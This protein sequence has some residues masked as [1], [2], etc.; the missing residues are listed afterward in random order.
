MSDATILAFDLGT[1][2]LKAA[3]ISSKA[4]VLD[5][6]V[7]P[8]EVKLLPGGGAEQHPDAWWRAMVTAAHRLWGRG[9]VKAS[10]VVGIALSSQW[11]G[12]VAVGAKGDPLRAALIWMDSRGQ[13][14]VR[15]LVSGFPMVAGYGALKAVTWLRKTG[16]VP[17]L[18]GKDPVGHIAWLR[19]HEPQTYDDAAVFLEPKDWVNARLTGR[20]AASFDSIVLHWATDNRKVDAIAYDDDLLAMSGMERRKLPELLPASS[21][22]GT[23]TSAAAEALGVS[24]SVKVVAGSA[25]MH[26]AA[27]GA[28]TVE[29][30]Q[31]HLCLGTSSWLLAHVPFKKSDLRH[32]MTSLPSAIPG[33]Y[34]W[35][36]EQETAA[37]ALEHLV[38]R[39]FEQVG[40]GAFEQALARA[41]AVAP[42]AAGLSFLPWL[43]GERS[44][45]DDHRV[46]GGF[47]GL[48][49][50]H[51]QGHLVRA[52]LEGGA[53]NTRWLKQHVEANF[54]R[55]LEA[56]T[57]VGGGARSELWCQIHADVLGRP[58]RQ[59]EDPQLAN[60]R[61][62]GLSALVALGLASWKDVPALVPIRRTFEPDR[63]RAALYAE[64]F[65]QLLLEFK[66][67]REMS[68]RFAVTEHG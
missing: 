46:R 2:G 26:M 49:L 64:R 66:H 10:E 38:E 5:R 3:I 40:P 63:E 31:A 13:E 25:D 53:L 48:S 55:P 62:A 17:S 36:N 16:G 47:V 18:S 33:R 29:D 59:V 32:N 6:E 44:P 28:G 9:A 12:T 14:E 7:V 24:T 50:Q 61:G 15:R 68:R 51:G 20:I 8:L 52:V 57:V 11:G 67:R 23:L 41:G 60:A 56:V 27:I 4:A 21:I 65:E 39:L 19:R 58:V 37:G 1:S 43:H 22:L 42:G 45:V 35:C 54:G 30:Y 34:L